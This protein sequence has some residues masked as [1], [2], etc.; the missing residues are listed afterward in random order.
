MIRC[1]LGRKVWAVNDYLEARNAG[2]AAAEAGS[3]S[4]V[5]PYA[6]VLSPLEIALGR[7]PAVRDQTLAAQWLAGWRS[8]AGIRS[9]LGGM[10]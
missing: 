10:A 1:Y 8:L 4:T 7:Q 3:A 2:R 5:N 6:V 9:N